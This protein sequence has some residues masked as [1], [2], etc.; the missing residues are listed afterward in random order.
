MKYELNG[1]KPK[2]PTSMERALKALRRAM[3][4]PETDKHHPLVL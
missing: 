1:E 2:A 4:K 3:K